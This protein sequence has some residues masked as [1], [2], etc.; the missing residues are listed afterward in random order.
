MIDTLD[1]LPC[2]LR[3]ARSAAQFAQLNR[4][5][6]VALLQSTFATLSTQ[7][8]SGNP[9]ELFAQLCELFRKKTGD[10]DPYRGIRQRF[11]TSI[12]TMESQFYH[13]VEQAQDSFREAVKLAVVGNIIDFAGGKEITEAL[14][15]QRI[16]D[17]EHEGL[18][19]DD[20]DALVQDLNEAHTLLL[21]G[22]NCGEIVFDKVFLR[23]VKKRWPHLQVHYGVRGGAILNDSIRADA[24]DVGIGDWAQIIDN[25][26]RAPG[27]LLHRVSPEF[28]QV[29]EAA[30]VVMAKGQG[31]FESLHDAPRKIH[32]LF[33]SKCPAVCKITGTQV[34]DLLCMTR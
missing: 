24:E 16:L 33:M 17:V 4:E 34:G 2:V 26:D 20:C 13:Q 9:V 1:C 6:E 11:N 29:F 18:A 21:L 15:H 31:N 10:D 7:D 27:T 23:Y 32:F 3:Q 28:L 8:F 5:E 30:D 22:D 19:R 25:G 14:V 12:L